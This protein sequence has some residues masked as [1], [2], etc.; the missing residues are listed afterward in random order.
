MHA[1]RIPIDLAGECNLLE[2]GSRGARQVT[3][4][5]ESTMRNLDT[6]MT[7]DCFVERPIDN[8]CFERDS[9]LGKLERAHA[10]ATSEELREANRKHVT[11]GP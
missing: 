3:A 1:I 7:G 10:I 5:F 9:G 11:I 6:C 2:L 8:G 4:Q